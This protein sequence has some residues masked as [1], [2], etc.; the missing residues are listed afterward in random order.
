ML[1]ERAS[2]DRETT[3]ITRPP[4]IFDFAERAPKKEGSAQIVTT[5]S[6]PRTVAD[7]MGIS[8]SG[9]SMIER[10]SGWSLLR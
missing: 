7:V 1:L 8:A 9:G 5:M 10:R 6:S 3:T 2:G 4:P